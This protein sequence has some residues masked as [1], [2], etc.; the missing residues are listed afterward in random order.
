LPIKEL[1]GGIGERNTLPT[2]FSNVRPRLTQL[3][4]SALQ[5]ES[6]PL[7]THILLGI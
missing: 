6:D 4:L 1:A 5:V 3:L 7:N 2:I